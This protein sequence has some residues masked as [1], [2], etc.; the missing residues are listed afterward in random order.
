MTSCLPTNDKICTFCLFFFFWAKFSKRCYW[1]WL[2]GI[3]RL[4]LPKFNLNFEEI[5]LLSHPIYYQHKRSKCAFIAFFQLQWKTVWRR[6]IELATNQIHFL[7]SKSKHTFSSLHT[8][9][10]YIRHFSFLALKHRQESESFKLSC[11]YCIFEIFPV[12]DQTT[13]Q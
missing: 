1:R 3:K 8:L 13:Q 6:H 11:T 2:S 12:V 4:I 7:Y 9:F 10:L 5:K